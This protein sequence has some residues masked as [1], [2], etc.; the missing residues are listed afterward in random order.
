M[1]W[2]TVHALTF[3]C[4][5]TLID[6]EKGI[7]DVLRPWADDSGLRYDDDALLRAYA[8]AESSLEEAN[9]GMPYSELLKQVF[10]HVGESLGGPVTPMD[11]ERLSASVGDWPPFP[12][13]INA[14]HRLAQRYRLIIVSNVDHRSFA[15]TRRRLGVDFH[16]VVTAEDVG[17]YKPD[18]RMFERAWEAAAALGVERFHCVHV[19]QSLYHD[20]VPV[21]A[22]G[23]RTIWIDRRQGRPGGATPPPPTDVVP[24]LRIES[25]AALA[26]LCELAES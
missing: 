6:W 19:A 11:S 15:M 20:H 8:E 13:T 3:D 24:D 12:D 1:D 23:G 9:P 16:A 21:K 25:L 14:L 4:Y 2:N 5:G 22:L 7:L 18:Q 26:D 10:A 17:A